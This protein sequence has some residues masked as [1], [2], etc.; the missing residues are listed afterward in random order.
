MNHRICALDASQDKLSSGDYRHCQGIRNSIEKCSTD[1]QILDLLRGQSDLTL[2]ET[3]CGHIV[4]NHQHRLC[5]LAHM[6]K[7]IQIPSLEVLHESLCS[8][9]NKQN[10]NTG[11]IYD[12][13]MGNYEIIQP[14]IFH[15]IRCG[16]YNRFCQYKMSDQAKHL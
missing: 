15:R 2:I 3:S 5:I 1:E 9:C 16:M 6:K 13:V 7:T 4:T 11:L 12:A 8:L 14:N 10:K